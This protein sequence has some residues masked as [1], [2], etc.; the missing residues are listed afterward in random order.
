MSE[1]P[2][3]ERAKS[4]AFLAQNDSPDL[5]LSVEDYVALGRLPHGARS[6]AGKRIV[7]EAIGKPGWRR[8]GTIR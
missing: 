2:A 3:A 7:D 5:R 4:I 6:A 8:S 1:W